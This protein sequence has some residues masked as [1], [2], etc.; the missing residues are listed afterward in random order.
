[1]AA[2]ALHP[3]HRRALLAGTLAVL[4]LWATI[5]VATMDPAELGRWAERVHRWPALVLAPPQRASLALGGGKLQKL[6]VRAQVLEQRALPTTS[7]IIGLAP[8]GSRL[9]VASFGDGAWLLDGDR[10]QPL[11]IGTAVNALAG[12]GTV[13]WAAT[14]DGAYR[15][16]VDG[17]AERLASGAFTAVTTWRGQPWFTS[18]RGLSTVDEQGFVTFGAEH[19]LVPMR[20]A[21][22]AACGEVLCLGAEDGLWLFDG[23]TAVRHTSASGAL[24]ADEVT[25][26]AY[27]GAAIWAGTFDA[28]FARLNRDPRRLAPSDGLADGRIDARALASW[29]GLLLAGTPSGLSVVRGDAAGLAPMHEVTSV[30]AVGDA[31]W[32]GFSGGIARLEVSAP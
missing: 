18:P 2:L 5:A 32:I 19:G 4:T 14:N 23:R 10:L 15:V 20:P 17:T 29:R 31:L 26:V 24:P 22:V 9:A 7:P 21:S 3:P 8:L 30:A 13:L 12:D 27:D 28:G 25:A 16:R 11:P 6:S 1:M